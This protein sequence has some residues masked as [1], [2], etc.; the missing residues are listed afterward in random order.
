[1]SYI[2]YVKLR[3]VRNPLKAA[4]YIATGIP[5]AF[6]IANYTVPPRVISVYEKECPFFSID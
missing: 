3:Y 1:M 5:V 4:R 2:L 6:R